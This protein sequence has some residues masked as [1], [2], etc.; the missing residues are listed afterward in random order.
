MPLQRPKLKKRERAL[1]LFGKARRWVFHAFDRDY[2]RKSIDRR[3]GSCKRCGACCNLGFRCPLVRADDLNGTKCAR[4]NIRTRNCSAFPIDEA[5]LRD[6]D[7]VNAETPCGFSFNSKN[8]STRDHLAKWLFNARVGKWFFNSPIGK[9][10]IS[11]NGK[12]KKK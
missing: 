12:Y 11:G 2:V 7:I 4:F 6:R 1:L 8:G 9:W 10:F 3:H 5:D